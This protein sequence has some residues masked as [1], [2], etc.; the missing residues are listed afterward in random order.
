LR[1]GFA[2]LLLTGLFTAS[3]PASNVA[4][5]RQADPDA[6][7]E[8]SA[9]PHNHD[10]FVDTRLTF[11]F[12][13]DDVLAPTGQQVPIS[14]LPGFGDRD[15]YQLFFDNL[16]FRFSSRETLTHLVV[17]KKMPSFF[18]NLTTEAALVVRLNLE[19]VALS[20]AGSFIRLEYS[21]WVDA[22]EDGISLTAFP[23]DSERFRLGY[24]FALS[25][26][27]ADFVPR[28]SLMR[29]PGAKI[30]VDR[31]IGYYFVGMKTIPARVPLNVSLD[32]GG[33][34]TE[35]ETVRVNETQYSVLGGAGVDLFGN[36][37][38]V[39]AG[40]GYFQQGKLDLPS[41]PKAQVY[42]I[43]TAARAVY[44]R[45]MGIPESI[46]FQLYRN[47]PDSPF[48]P[49]QP[50]EYVPGEFGYM[51]S[52]EGVWI[53]QHLADSDQTNA[54]TFEDA[55]AGAVRGRLKYGFW[56][57]EMTAL[58]RDLSFILKNVP[59][60]DPF[61]SI[62]QRM[63]INP[64]F[65]MAATTDY[66]FPGPRLTLGLSV[67]LQLPS[68]ASSPITAGPADANRTL[69][70]RDEGQFSILPP[71]AADAVPVFG[72]RLQARVDLS[73]MVYTFAW[74]QFVRDENQT[75]LVVSEEEGTRRIF[76]RPNQLGF[77]VSLAARY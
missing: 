39:E 66:H 51:L 23:F 47:A 34:E 59:S 65:F 58:Y 41:Y 35:V 16:N 9:D 15:A 21:P 57:L 30:Q 42:S 64:E 53:R 56:R 28:A 77:G 20:D 69:V 38:R 4:A 37:L 10:A 61:L 5:Q 22:P 2:T 48:R 18:E 31:G 6:A 52:A 32:T 17:Y 19:E 24:L 67:G 8:G 72:G 50:T 46:D 45:N 74:V 27:G 76:Q 12:G 14:P 13:D 70:V 73:E 1:W 43:G 60:L 54:T 49:F 36:T 25:F 3:W 33:T 71:G 26:G 68:T 11:T 75:R 55:F 63:T 40:A 29:A 7:Q 62:P 44:H